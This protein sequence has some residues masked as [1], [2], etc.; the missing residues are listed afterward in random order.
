MTHVEMKEKA[1]HAMILDFLFLAFLA[2]IVAIAWFLIGEEIRQIAEKERQSVLDAARIE[3]CAESGGQ[4]LFTGAG[5]NQTPIRNQDG[6]VA[7]F[8]QGAE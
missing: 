5:G 8:P 7:C 1:S 3:A 4:S 6:A 2:M